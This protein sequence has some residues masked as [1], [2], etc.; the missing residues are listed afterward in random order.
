MIRLA[1]SL[2]TPGAEFISKR[3]A[4]VS[5]TFDVAAGA[6]LTAQAKPARPDPSAGLDSFA[7]LVDGNTPAEDVSAPP[8]GPQPISAPQG[9]ASTSAQ[10]AASNT[11]SQDS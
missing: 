2:L 3:L 1:R 5:V 8:P 4:V 9:P 10:T 11:P 7:A 6:S